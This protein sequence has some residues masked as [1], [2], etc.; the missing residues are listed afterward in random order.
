[1]MK[2]R[3]AYE[4]KY[5]VLQKFSLCAISERSIMNL[6]DILKGVNK[7]GFIDS[8]KARAKADKKTIVL[9]ESMDRRTWEAAEMILAEGIADLVI[10]GTPEEVAE[11]SKGLNVSGA[12]VIDPNT[13]DK[14]QSY[15]DEFVELR[16]K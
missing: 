12:T 15:I 11:N 13:S 6:S 1:M 3:S 7:M 5:N 14:L 16:K 4:K 9:P 2:K 8:I 10:L